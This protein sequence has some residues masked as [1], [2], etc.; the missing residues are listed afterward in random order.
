M[1]SDS[2]TIIVTVNGLDKPGVTSSLTNILQ[3]HSIEILDISQSVIHRILTLSMILKIPEEVVANSVLK[4]LLY[5]AHEMELTL[6]FDPLSQK[7]Y[8]G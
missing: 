5:K 8:S 6:H 4:E 7:E 2:N 1:S 3:E